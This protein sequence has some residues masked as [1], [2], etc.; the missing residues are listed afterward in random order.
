M[1]RDYKMKQLTSSKDLL[2]NFIGDWLRKNNHLK[3]NR[4]ADDIGSHQSQISALKN[5][6]IKN[7]SFELLFSLVIKLGYN[8]DIYISKSTKKVGHIKV[9][10]KL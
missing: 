3:Q 1:K 9:N 2:L 4:V 6:T 5:K 7:T 8:I 10:S